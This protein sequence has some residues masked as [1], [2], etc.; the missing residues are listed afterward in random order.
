MCFT[1]SA[2]SLVYLLRCIERYNKTISASDSPAANR[3]HLKLSLVT[4]AT[5]T[6]SNT[7]SLNIV[8]V[9]ILNSILD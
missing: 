9:K 3:T 2:F 5:T 1:T 4:Q 6:V 8:K 7:F